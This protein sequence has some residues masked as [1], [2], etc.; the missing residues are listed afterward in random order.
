MPLP[1]STQTIE[2]TTQ[3][4]SYPI[5]IGRGLGQSLAEA[6]AARQAAGIGQAVIT[7]ATVR[8]HCAPLFD[9]VFAG[10]PILEL[11]AGEATKSFAALG[12]CCEFLA[13]VRMERRDHLYAVGGGVIGDLG[14]F[15]AACYLRGITFD[16]VPTTLLAMVDSSVGGKTGINLPAGKNLVGAF[17]QPR[18]VWADV[19][20]LRTLPAREF[21]A[22]MAEVVKHGLLGSL[23]LVEQLETGPRL[24]AASPD[25]P[26]VI[27][28]NCAIKAAVVAADEREQS[29]TGGRALLN[30]GHTFGHA[31]EAV[32]GYG[33]YLHG[34]AV[35]IGLVLAARLSVACGL[36]DE[37]VIDRVCRLL[38]R[39]DLPTTLRAPLPLD[40]LLAAMDHDK[41][42]TGGDIKF[43]LLAAVGAARTQRGIDRNRVAALWRSAGAR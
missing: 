5:H 28:Q 30:L 40:D 33:T 12:Q 8:A 24:D 3:A 15:A 18:T 25:L 38:A 26:A 37:S 6:V 20:L 4:S 17:H 9:T 29:A 39:Y 21:V 41:K 11:P 2:V 7:D 43:V 13:T 23:R 36:V 22:G 1:T 32:A 14:G 31:I 27:A 10:L 16:Q 19:D 35:A 34:E 42:A